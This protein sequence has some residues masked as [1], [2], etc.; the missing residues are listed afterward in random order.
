MSVAKSSTGPIPSGRGILMPRLPGS[1]K[2]YVS[3]ADVMDSITDGGFTAPQL[4]LIKRECQR[5]LT[6]QRKAGM[7][8]AGATIEEG[9]RVMI[10]DNYYLKTMW[11]VVGTVT[12]IVSHTSGKN[13]WCSVKFKPDSLP[14]RRPKYAVGTDGLCHVAGNCVDP[15]PRT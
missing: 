4:T 8:M 14:G 7:I 12:E 3:Y 11:G 13:V 15:I 1:G 10:N 5:A 2:S 9:D 6:M